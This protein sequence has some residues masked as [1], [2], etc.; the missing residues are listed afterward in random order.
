MVRVVH[1]VARDGRD[2]FGRWLQAQ[3]PHVRVRLQSRVDRY[4]TRKP[5]TTG[6]SA[7]ACWSY[8]YTLA[9]D[10]A[11]TTAATVRTLVILL[12]GG[13]KIPSSATSNKHRRCG[14]STERRSEMPIRE[15][16]ASEYIRTPEEIAEYLNVTL[17]EMGD[18]PRLL[19]WR[20]VTLSR[21]EAARLR[22]RPI[23]IASPSLG[24]RPAKSAP[25]YPRE[26][27]RRVRCEAPVNS[28]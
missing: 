24:H 5:A 3:A 7:E 13:T 6:E 26:G 25:G 28:A 4:G 10:T 14:A 21:R 19:M 11:C 15:H 8:G 1:Y 16:D 27:D 17:E 23:W 2:H 22:G 9:L 12:A 18:D 20:F